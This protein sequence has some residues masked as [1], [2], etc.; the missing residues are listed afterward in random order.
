MG[1][2]SVGLNPENPGSGRMRACTEA[3]LVNLLH[4]NLLLEL[5]Q[6]QL[7]AS[8]TDIEMPVQVLL[9]NMELNGF[10][11]MFCRSLIRV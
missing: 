6:R 3:V 4:R 11:E 1:V 2:G 5:Q 9:A 8:F 10:G 7:D